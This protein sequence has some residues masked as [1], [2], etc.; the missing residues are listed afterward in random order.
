M[1]IRSGTK[2]AHFN[3]AIALLPHALA[4]K[5]VAMRG[6]EAAA[7]A[8]VGFVLLHRGRRERQAIR[9]AAPLRKLSGLLHRF[10]VL[11]SLD[12]QPRCLWRRLHD[13]YS[14]HRRDWMAFGI[15]MLVRYRS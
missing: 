4:W 11:R 7:L 1:S 5:H 9:P 8:S 13:R 3:K 2:D 12:R 6:D 14:D 10:A 15:K